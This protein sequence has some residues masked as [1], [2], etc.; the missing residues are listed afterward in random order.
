MKTLIYQGKEIELNYSTTLNHLIPHQLWQCGLSLPALGLAGYLYTLPK[1]WRLSVTHLSKQLAMS[2][3]TCR[4]YLKEIFTNP[5]AREVFKV[6][7]V[8]I[9]TYD[10]EEGFT[11]Y[12]YASDKEELENFTSSVAKDVSEPNRKRV[13]LIQTQQQRY[14]LNLCFSIK[15]SAFLKKPAAASPCTAVA[16]FGL[17]SQDDKKV[18]SS[19]IAKNLNN[20][21]K[22]SR[23][24]DE[25][26][27]LCEQAQGSY[28]SGNDRRV[29]EAIKDLS[30]KAESTSEKNHPKNAQN[31]ST[32][33]R[34]SKESLKDSSSKRT[35]EKSNNDLTSFL[36]LQSFSQNEQEAIKLWIRYK[37]ESTRK[38]FK[39]S[40]ID[41]QLRKITRLKEQGQDICAVIE[42]SLDM[43][44][45]GLF[46]QRDLAFL[47]KPAA[48]SPCTAV[49]GFGL[50]SRISSPRLCDRHPS[51]ISAHGSKSHDSS[52]KILESQVIGVKPKMPKNIGGKSVLRVENV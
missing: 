45:Q 22:D 19:Y 41:F 47:K 31:L 8:E 52:S 38:P 3:N 30:R 51:L 20:S 1:Q 33:K 23:I 50:E 37:Q 36:D 35:R 44:W 9:N 2:K 15:D 21:A 6:K 18:D 10:F 25:K 11:A 48:A 24:C 40:Q 39:P 4:K 16:G 7:E 14:L 5:K 43:G 27:L 34:D 17:E 46:P 42:K 49:A 26:S 28:L 32:I 12:D 29:C 13:L